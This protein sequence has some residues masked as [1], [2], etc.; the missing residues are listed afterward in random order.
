MKLF[1]PLRSALVRTLSLLTIALATCSLAQTTI[2]VG[3]GQAYTTIQSGINA[4]SNGDTVLV[5]PGTYNENINFNG[6]AITVTSSGGAAV[7]TISGPNK[8]AA[9]LF[10]NGETRDSVLSNFTVTVGGQSYLNL[11]GGVYLENSSPTILH[12]VITNT[13]CY[14]IDSQNSSPLIQGNEISYVQAQPYECSFASGTGIWFYG[15]KSGMSPVALG[16]TI[17]NNTESGL[18]DAGGN[19]GAGIAVWNSTVVIEGNIIRNNATG[20]LF[21]P[22]GGG[23]GGGIFFES[24]GGLVFNNLIYGNVSNLAGGGIAFGGFGSG[25]PSVIL[26]NNTIVDNSIVPVSTYSQVVPGGQQLYY[27]GDGDG[28][29]F[30]NNIVSG[31]TTNP[32]I[33]C[34]SNPGTQ[35]N[36]GNNNFFNTVGPVIGGPMGSPACTYPSGTSGNISANP[37]FVSSASQNYHVV[38]GSPGIDAGINSALQIAESAGASIT[39]DLDGKAR[40]QATLSPTCIVDMGAYEYPGSQASACSIAETLQSSLNPS[41]LG[42]TV[43]FTAQL[44]STN[45]VPTGSVQFTDGSAILGTATVSTAGA[46]TFS[47]SAL[48]IGSHTIT[49]TY[50]PTGT[51]AAASTSLVQVVNGY[52]TATTLTCS[53]SSINISGTALLTAA[54]ASSSGAPTGSIAFTDNGTSLA[55]QA[56]LNGSTSFTYTG[57]IAG[58]HTLTATY[59]PTGTFAP[60]SASCSE[61]VNAL[62]T[63]SV[64]AVNPVTSAY[65]SPVTL[66]TT[67]SPAAP[68]GHGN[69]TGTVTFYNGATVIGTGTLANGVATLSVSSLPGG[70][71]NLTCVYGGSYTYS[72]SNCNTVPEV[73]TAVPTSTLLTV[74]PNPAYL[75]QSVTMVATLSSQ[76]SAQVASGSVTFFDGTTS[77][78]TPPVNASG[79]ATF[80]TST[81]AVGTHP[82]TATFNPANTSFVT[83]SSPIVNEVILASGFTIALSPATIT[84]PPG[85]TGA[86]TIQLAS[87][88]NFAGP[89]TLSYGTLPTYA[90]ASINP[91]TV[92]LTA[93]GTGSSSLALNTLLKSSNTLPAWPGSKAVS[94]VFAAFMVWL[95]PLRSSRHKRLARLLGVAL[96]VVALQAITGCTNQ[97]YIGNAVAAGTYQL[98]VTATDVN[99]NSQTA[100]L[101]VVVT[102]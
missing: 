8:T 94:V 99:H 3:S 30:Y 51:F 46:A 10:M 58:T 24:G 84:L 12:N 7:T 65:G 78:G 21:S 98:P 5:A 74:K 49:A 20:E 82:I 79:T 17:E 47:T 19:G 37:D 91:S 2:N 62:P 11:M 36:Y 66:T 71:N 81:L 97:W 85:A 28:V 26:I 34:Y 87:V 102:Q 32:S 72:T 13:T 27:D 40:V 53:P 95:I 35:F 39:T 43:T 83:S 1:P 42:Q 15:Q 86:V 38:N 29:F 31:S 70:S 100:T 54:V 41:T 59:A 22:A 45:G 33:V 50:Q 93:D 80:T 68:P 55:T 4:A 63:T 44:S 16:N 90:T 89:L 23:Q 77:L 69:P 6:K 96:L 73:I 56:L 18:E 48:A 61:V 25:A 92:S 57:S 76:T 75:V 52:S 88:G 9:V 60:S 14:G 64:L 67:V 101:T